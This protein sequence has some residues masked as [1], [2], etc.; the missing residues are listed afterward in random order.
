MFS[1]VVKVLFPL[2]ICVF[3]IVVALNRFWMLAILLPPYAGFISIIL[4]A[5]N[6]FYLVRFFGVLLAAS[7][8]VGMLMGSYFVCQGILEGGLVKSGALP[9][10]NSGELIF[11]PIILVAAIALYALAYKRG[12]NKGLMS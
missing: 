2:S 8:P 11:G 5:A 6:A 10:G 7:A 9:L 1:R 4:V 12:K 3:A